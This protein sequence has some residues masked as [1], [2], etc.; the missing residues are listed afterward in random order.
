M[1]LRIV[2]GVDDSGS[3]RRALRWAIDEAAMLDAELDVVHAYTE[4]VVIVPAPLAGIPATTPDRKGRAE[5]LLHRLTSEHWPGPR[6]VH[7][8]SR[9]SPSKGTPDARW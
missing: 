1:A 4:P 9:S 6:V 8:P 2:V 5:A 3:A 7:A